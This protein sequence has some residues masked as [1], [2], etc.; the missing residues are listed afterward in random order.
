[1]SMNPLDPGVDLRIAQL[2]VEGM[3]GTTCP[4]VHP[5]SRSS[6]MEWLNVVANKVSQEVRAH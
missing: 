5:H 1:M 6:L 3:V 2:H 4:H